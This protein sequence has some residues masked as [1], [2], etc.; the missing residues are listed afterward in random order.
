LAFSPDGTR[1]IAGSGDGT[2]AVWDVGLRA[3]PSRACRIANRNLTQEEWA[4]YLGD[5][6]YHKTCP[7]LP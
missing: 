3:W 2:V 1:L 6:P 4:Q 7:D 5:M